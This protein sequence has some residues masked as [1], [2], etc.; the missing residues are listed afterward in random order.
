MLFNTL[1]CC[2]LGEAGMEG[3]KERSAEVSSFQQFTLCAL[4]LM[5]LFS[6]L[7]YDAE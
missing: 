6:S 5:Q 1:P 7:M 3:E 4:S 2:R